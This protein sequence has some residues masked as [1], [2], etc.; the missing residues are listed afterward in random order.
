MISLALKYE[1]WT[2]NL[3]SR[4]SIHAH[5]LLLLGPVVW[6]QPSDLMW[7]YSY[8]SFLCSTMNAQKNIR[9]I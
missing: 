7:F 2:E 6:A 9:N 4:P 1:H 3:R 5:D 8:I